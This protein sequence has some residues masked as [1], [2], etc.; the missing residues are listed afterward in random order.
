MTEHQIALYA[1]ARVALPPRL[2]LRSWSWSPVEFGLSTVLRFGRG[3][4]LVRITV[5]YPLN[6]VD[7]MGDAIEL[8]VNQLL[9]EIEK[10]TREHYAGE[11]FARELLG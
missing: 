2:P 6:A 11:A 9:A 3:R 10:A 1:A 8:T 4:K 5:S 7:L